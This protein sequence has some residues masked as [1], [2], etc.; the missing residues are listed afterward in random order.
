M[1]KSFLLALV[2]AVLLCCSC[3]KQ[4]DYPYVMEG[5]PMY[6]DWY[7]HIPHWVGNMSGH[8]LTISYDGVDYTVK[9][10][11]FYRFKHHA[12]WHSFVDS[13]YFDEEGYIKTITLNKCKQ[14]PLIVTYDDGVTMNYTIADSETGLVLTPS[15]H[16]PFGV[17]MD[18]SGVDYELQ[19]FYNYFVFGRLD[20]EYA[21]QNSTNR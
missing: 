8:D 4:P 14:V 10:N 2:A 5:C 12:P 3:E 16:N 18:G 6:E 11:D 13:T 17:Q 20:Y 1:K 9:D 15:M 19:L 7:S 21:K